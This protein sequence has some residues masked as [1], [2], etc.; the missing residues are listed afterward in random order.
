MKTASPASPLLVLFLV[1]VT[2]AG[3]CAHEG[4]ASGPRE[5]EA[6]AAVTGVPPERPS[7]PVD[8]GGEPDLAPPP[9]VDPLPPDAAAK[10]ATD[11]A[12]AV[13][14]TAAPVAPDAGALPDGAA[15]TADGPASGRVSLEQDLAAK[16]VGER[17]TTAREGDVLVFTG[18]FQAGKFGGPQGH[19]ISLA[20]SPGRDYLFEYRV[21]FE[22]DFPW[23]K[24]GKLPGLA[25]GN[26]PT[27]CVDVNGGGF[28]ARMMWKG[29][30]ALVGYTYDLDQMT[31]CGNSL[32]TGFSFK[33]GQWYRIKERV[34]INTGKN[35]D[36]VLQIWVD[37]RLVLDKKDMAWMNEAPANRIDLVLFHAFFGGSTQGWAPARDCA[38]SFAAP[39]ATRLAE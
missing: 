12:V 24:G 11:V 30:G 33:A 38:I 22:G 23:T 6:D 36:G 1:A 10:G 20:L 31:G 18:T 26:R 28:S 29:G 21:R 39:F 7:S 5:D 34:R 4:S 3:A 32:A 17:R 16:W 19:T 14:V 27:G 25:G 8:R 2:G 13:D 15:M 37:D 9:R 35:G